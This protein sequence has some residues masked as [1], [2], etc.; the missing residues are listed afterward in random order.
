MIIIRYAEILLIAAESNIELNKDLDVALTYINKIRQ[1]ADVNMPPLIGI[2]GQATLRVAL[3]H[4][5]TVEL[6]LEGNRFFDI[7]RWRIAE[8]T[9]NMDKVDGM[10]YVDKL[11]GEL[12]TV[13][14][15][16]KKKFS[17]RDYLWP[18]PYNERQLN[19][20]L[21]QNEGWN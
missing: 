8:S 13:S 18:I 5:R 6:A 2:N 19:A 7:R 4:E 12:V 15:D 9:C 21:T 3:R 11:S 17:T 14:T 1:R 20:N 16:Y 10:R